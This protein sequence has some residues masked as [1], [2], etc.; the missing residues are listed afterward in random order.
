MLYCFNLFCFSSESDKMLKVFQTSF[1][2]MKFVRIVR[3]IWNTNNIF[4]FHWRGIAHV[5]HSKDWHPNSLI[6]IP[7]KWKSFMERT[8]KCLSELVFGTDRSVRYLN[9]RKPC[10]CQKLGTPLALSKGTFL[11][12]G[13]AHCIVRMQN[14]VPNDS[15][16]QWPLTHSL[17]YACMLTH[18]SSHSLSHQVVM[19]LN[20]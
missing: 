16:S 6:N 9:S 5:I 13:C 19:D 10:C 20:G 17:R 12:P 11:W 3:T 4:N 18:T 14:N 1:L 8:W 2:S 7:R 15:H